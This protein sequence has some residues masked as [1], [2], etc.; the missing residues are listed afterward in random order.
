MDSDLAEAVLSLRCASRA[1]RA[2]G[3]TEEHK[4]VNKALA[5]VLARW[6]DEPT[7]TTSLD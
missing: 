1:L 2:S 6:M 3:W 5:A 4:A 7:Q